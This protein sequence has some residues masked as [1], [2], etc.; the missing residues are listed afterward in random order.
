MRSNLTGVR[1]A[2]GLTAGLVAAVAIAG[3]GGTGPGPGGGG[4]PGR[5]VGRGAARRGA[6]T[7]RS[8]LPAPVAPCS[9]P[10]AEPPPHALLQK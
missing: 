3:R 10:V 9:R 1:P 2:L 4:T 8:C 7:P 5:R 6:R